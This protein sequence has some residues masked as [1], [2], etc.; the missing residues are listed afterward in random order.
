M[1]QQPP[2]P[3]HQSALGDL[4][5]FRVITQDTLKLVNTGNQAGA[6]TRVTDLETAWDNGEARLK[7]KDP[8]AWH[9]LDGKIDAV[10]R[11]LRS[12]QPNPTDEKK[13]LSTL[14]AALH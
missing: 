2:T 10:L 8:T 7:P 14:L 11:A 9:D 12:T 5:A 3:A 13:A 4:T 6:T 1:A